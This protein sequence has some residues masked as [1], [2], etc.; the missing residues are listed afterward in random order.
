MVQNDMDIQLLGGGLLQ[1]GQFFNSL[2]SLKQQFDIRKRKLANEK[3]IHRGLDKLTLMT[4]ILLFV[5]FS[6]YIVIFILIHS[7]NQTITRKVNMLVT[8]NYHNY[9]HSLLKNVL[10]D[11]LAGDFNMTFRSRPFHEEWARTFEETSHMD[12]EFF[13][14]LDRENGF[15]EDEMLRKLITGNL[16]EASPAEIALFVGNPC[17]KVMNGLPRQ[18]IK[19]IYDSSVYWMGSL[20][21]NFEASNKTHNDSVKAMSYK[22]QIGL[23]FASFG[24]AKIAFEKISERMESQLHKDVLRFNK[25]IMWTVVIYS[26]IYVLV[27]FVAWRWVEKMLFKESVKWKGLFKMIPPAIILSNKLIKFYLFQ[28]K[29]DTGNREE[30]YG[31]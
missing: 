24:Y 5:I 20:Y 16:C 25:R 10:P 11:Y 9:E 13:Q 29:K 8:F 15:G 17:D 28:D 6:G 2:D 30:G 31:Y 18:G 26:V 4:L 1:K 3:G 12:E 22:E 21:A 14:I 7:Q 23:E 27:V 19:G